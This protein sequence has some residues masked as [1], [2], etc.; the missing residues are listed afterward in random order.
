MHLTPMF[1]L[2]PIYVLTVEDLTCP[3]LVF[4]MPNLP[5]T[6]ILSLYFMFLCDEQ[7]DQ[8]IRMKSRSRGTVYFYNHRCI[9]YLGRQASYSCKMRSG[10]SQEEEPT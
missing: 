1:T 9:A 2:G 3:S 6:T 4:H 8:R 10:V 7:H 5:H